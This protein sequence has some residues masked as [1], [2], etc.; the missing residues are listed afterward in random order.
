MKN[1]EPEGV[2]SDG[3]A[4]G[5][6]DKGLVE[7]GWLATLGWWWGGDGSQPPVDNVVVLEL[8]VESRHDADAERDGRRV[9][10]GGGCH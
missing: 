4:E 7:G 8:S 6:D 2:I 1:A 5:H 9:G 10:S 3:G